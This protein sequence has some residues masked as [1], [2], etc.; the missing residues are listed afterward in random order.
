MDKM[1]K[2]LTAQDIK[3]LK[4]FEAF[5]RKTPFITYRKDGRI[6]RHKTL[7]K[8]VIVAKGQALLGRR[9]FVDTDRGKFTRSIKIFEPRTKIST[10][11]RRRRR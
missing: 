7:I 4:R 8:A 1:V 3:A 10:K 5:K 2:K 6:D 9:G 11:K